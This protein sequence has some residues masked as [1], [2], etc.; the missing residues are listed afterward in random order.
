MNGS[1]LATAFFVTY[2]S[3]LATYLC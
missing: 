2:S 3:L 1:L